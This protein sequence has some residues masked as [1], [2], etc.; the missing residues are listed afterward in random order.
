MSYLKTPR[1]CLHCGNVYF[2]K[3]GC[4]KYCSNSCYHAH[5]LNRPI[6]DRMLDHIEKTS[7]CWLW[8]GGINQ[9]GYGRIQ[10]QGQAWLAHRLMYHLTTGADVDGVVIRHFVCDNPPCV[11]PSHL[12]VGSKADNSQDA[13]S[14][15]R[16]AHGETSYAKLTEAEVR[17]IWEDARTDQAI[18]DA[19]NVARRTISHIKN[20]SSWK[21]LGLGRNPSRRCRK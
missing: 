3:H 20:G 18:A 21:H 2:S 14:K 9:M 16:H 11:N 13:V 17:A 1:P 5:K 15:N 19:F 12:R 8:T 7:H 6:M 4:V 10:Y